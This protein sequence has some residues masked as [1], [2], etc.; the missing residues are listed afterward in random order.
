LE[1][2]EHV[3]VFADRRDGNRLECSVGS[4]SAWS[5]PRVVFRSIT[6]AGRPG[7]R[8]P[9][10]VRARYRPP[11]DPTPHDPV[12]ATVEL[13]FATGTGNDAAP[14]GL[15]LAEEAAKAWQAVA[16]REAIR[17]NGKGL[18]GKAREGLVKALKRLTKFVQEN[19]HLPAAEPLLDE[20]RATGARLGPI[21]TAES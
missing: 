6:P 21:A 14:Y 17:L 16:V 7:V 13:A 20:L 18:Y 10:T 3:G 9:F 19:W 12:S 8:F 4:L 2:F 1:K 5:A 15:S 11:G